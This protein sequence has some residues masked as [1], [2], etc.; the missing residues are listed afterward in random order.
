LHFVQFWLDTIGEW[1]K[2]GGPRRP[3]IAL[4]CT[5]D[6]QDA[7][8]A[9]ANRSAVVDVIDFRY[10]W[11]A[12]NGLYDPQGGK[13]LSPRQHERLWKEEKRWKGGP[14]N[15]RDLAQMA[16]EYRVRYPAKAVIN[17][18][19]RASWAYLCAGGSLPQ[20]P[21]SVDARLLAA[22]P[23]MQPWPE[24][25]TK[26]RHVLREAGK[27]LLIYRGSDSELDL[28]NESG[29]FHVNVVNP[30]SG[31][32]TAGESVS[33]GKKIKLPNAEVI[34]LTKE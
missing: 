17:N 18:A 16:A 9:D 33:A 27:Q 26:D 21:R 6:V 10:W 3:I 1:E 11:Q 22:I 31:D 20:L 8:L 7:V 23:R 13:N 4:S 30:R 12:E 25:S 34:W 28:S 15:D 14:P 19:G 29:V 2:S 24:A 5:K 32:T